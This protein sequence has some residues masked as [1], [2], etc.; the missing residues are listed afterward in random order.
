MTSVSYAL[1]A[2]AYGRVGC[3]L[4]HPR[5]LTIVL[6]LVSVGFLLLWAAGGW[7]LILLGLLLVGAGQ[8]LLIPYLSVWLS[9][10]TTAALPGRA[11]GGLTTVLFL[12]A[13][14][15]PLVGQPL[16]AV[17]GFRGVSAAA[18]TL[19]LVSA[20]WEGGEAGSNA[21]HPRFHAPGAG[22]PAPGTGRS[23]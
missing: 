4:A 21:V 22:E 3:C 9:D 17:A 11:L 23:S 18:G 2:L 8:G 5:V 20:A 13:S 10:E 16:N 15:S 1:A 14:I 6:S 7:A 19:L 12:G